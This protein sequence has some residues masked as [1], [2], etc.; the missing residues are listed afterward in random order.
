MW[1]QRKEFC[2]DHTATTDAG[3]PPDP[4]LFP[5]YHPA[6]PVR[7]PGVFQALRQTTR[8]ARRRAHSSISVVPNQGKESVDL[9][10]RAD[11][12]RPA[13]LLYPYAAPESRHRSHSISAARAE[14]AADLEPR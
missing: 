14:A 6:L 9:H 3:R 10:L 11:D 7:R 5:D 8:S 13:L 12:L 4:P 1:S 2:C